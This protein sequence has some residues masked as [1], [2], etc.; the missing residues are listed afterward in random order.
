MINGIDDA[1]EFLR[2][3]HRG[4]HPHPGIDSAAIPKDLPYG[5]NRIYHE[6]GN[7]IEIEP[8][9]ANDYT[10]PFGTQ[11]ALMSLSRLKRVNGMIEFAWENQGNWSARCAAGQ[12]DPPVYTNA[13]D[14][15]GSSVFEVV[16]DSLNAFLI[17]LCLQ[18]AVMSAPILY[19]V[20]GPVSD[21]FMPTLP[22]LWLEG[23]CA[24]RDCRADFFCLPKEDLLVMGDGPVWL[25][26]HSAEASKFINP[27][28]ERQRIR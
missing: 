3:F 22:P 23:P 27:K 2:E 19:F 1:V 24:V 9:A 4:L 26:S 12:A 14:G 11:D 13:G 10:V 17:T 6:L 8:T 16:C 20:H 18:E 25:A 15:G 21:A 28:R 7:L 5:L